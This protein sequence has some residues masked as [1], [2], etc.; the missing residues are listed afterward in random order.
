MDQIVGP[1]G[2]SNVEAGLLGTLWVSF[3]IVGG[4]VGGPIIDR[5]HSYKSF[6]VRNFQ[7]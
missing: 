4:I 3:A 5:T 7:I 6:M 1:S 2:Y